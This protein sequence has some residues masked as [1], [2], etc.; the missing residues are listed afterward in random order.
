MH[1]GLLVNHEKVIKFLNFIW[2]VKI[3]LQIKFSGICQVNPILLGL[4]P[5]PVDK[6]CNFIIQFRYLASEKR[7]AWGKKSKNIK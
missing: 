3:K 4:L 7:T 1:R 5:G 2:S 6:K